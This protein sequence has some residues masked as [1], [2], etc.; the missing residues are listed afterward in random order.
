MQNKFKLDFEFYPMH[1]HAVLYKLCFTAITDALTLKGLRS[2]NKNITHAGIHVH[3]CMHNSARNRT[4]D[5][6]QTSQVAC[7]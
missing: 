4:A 1:N 2:P 6:L 5:L 3:A 7:Y